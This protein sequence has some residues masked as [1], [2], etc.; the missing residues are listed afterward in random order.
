[1]ERAERAIGAFREDLDEMKAQ[2]ALEE[3]DEEEDSDEDGA[4]SEEDM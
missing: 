1:M 2:I 3:G 4:E